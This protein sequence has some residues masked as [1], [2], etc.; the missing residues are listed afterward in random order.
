MNKIFNQI[1]KNLLLV[2]LFIRE[3]NKERRKIIMT[4]AG[5][6]WGTLTIILLLSF[7][8]GLTTQMMRSRK[9]LGVNIVILYAGQTGEEFQGLPQGRDI[10]FREADCDLLKS[11]IPDI[12]RIAGEYDSYGTVYKYKNKVVNE[13]VRG[14]SSIG[15]KNMRTHFPQEG[16]RFINNPDLINRRRV[17]FLGHDLKNRLMGDED[18]IGKTIMVDD[19]PF[20]VIGVMQ[21]KMQMGMYG[22]P[23]ANVGVIPA[24]TFKTV[25]GNEYLSRIIYQVNKI[26]RSDYV[27]NMV[28]ATLGSKYRFSPDDKSALHFWDTISN[29]K[30]MRKVFVG[31]NFFM[32]LIGAL[33]LVIAGVGVANIMFITVKKRTREIGIKRAIGGKTKLIKLQFIMEAL[34]I[35]LTGGLLGGGL[36]YVIVLGINS[37]SGGGKGFAEGMALQILGHPEFSWN[38]ALITAAILGFVGLMAGYFP[39]RRAAAVDPIEALHYE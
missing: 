25:Y 12:D 15:Y 37:L 35:D 27:N 30:I 28:K 18:A 20:K 24:T 6:A 26:D 39:A 17:I 2:K 8:Q 33:T 10:S 19:L 13:R 21:D 29:Q 5:I 36:A 4:V 3:L 22:G 16:G 34:L 14:V 7:G 11:R 9:G 32:G 31:I 1:G 38:V 23:D